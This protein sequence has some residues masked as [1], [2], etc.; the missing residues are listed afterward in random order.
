MLARARPIVARLPAGRPMMVEIGI[1]TGFM[2]EWLLDQR[3][4]LRWIGIDNW[5]PAE[6]QP[7]E[8]KAT[9][10]VHAV[11]TAAQQA[12]W[13]HEARQRL[14]RFGERAQIVK[15]DS[16]FAAH[17]FAHDSID[18]V[19]LDGRHDKAGVLADLNAWWPIVRPGGWLASHDFFEL[20][21]AVYVRG[22]LGSRAVLER[23]HGAVRAG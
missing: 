8:Y 18:L 6:E 9:G 15:E 13:E 14:T 3:T 4:D 20:G 5:L 7:E 16:A 22:Q 23:D 17:R 12:N 10:D 21:S 19:F 11:A 1:F 2:G